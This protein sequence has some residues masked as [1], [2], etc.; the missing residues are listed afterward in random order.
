MSATRRNGGCTVFNKNFILLFLVSLMTSFGFSMIIALISPY[1]VELGMDLSEAG[2]LAGVFSLSSLVVR[3]FGGYAADLFNKKMMCLLSTAM[4][5]AAVLGYAVMPGISALFLIRIFHGIAFGINGTVTISLVCKHVPE[6]RLGEGLGYFG[7]GQVISQIGGP[8]AGIFIKDMLGYK[9]LFILIFVMTALAVAVL[10]FVDDLPKSQIAYKR[11]KP[12]A[13]MFIAKECMVYAL[14][15]GV[16]SLGNAVV[17]SFLVLLGEERGIPGVSLVFMVNAAASFL[18]RLIGGR[19]SDK[20][21]FS[22]VVN[23]SLI[24][25]VISMMMIG[26]GS[27]LWV[28]LIAAALK[29]VGQDSGQ[30]SLQSTCIKSADARRGGIATSTFYIGSDIGQGFGPILGGVLSASSGYQQMFYCIAGIALLAMAGFNMYQRRQN[31]K[32]PSSV[33]KDRSGSKA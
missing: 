18:V 4:I 25:T 27:V 28:F 13:G 17:S 8:S 12:S 26:A 14:I 10:L 21:N 29:A 16:F 11:A 20:A 7:L 3:P 15:A 2:M 1:G 5:A 19:I 30:I 23:I 6:N 22:W 24:S 33:E 31:K 32:K 9:W